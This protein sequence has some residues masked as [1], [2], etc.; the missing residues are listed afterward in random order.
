MI[1]RAA[2]PDDVDAVAGLEDE[3]LGAEAWSHGLVAEGIRGTLA[4][5]HYLVADIG[6]RTVGHA[7]TSL[8]GDVAELQRIGVTASARRTGVARA[9]LDH[10]ATL[11]RASGADRLLLEVREDN[12][13][14]L[15][16]YA[17][18]GFAEIDRRRRYYRD[19][20]A[21][22]VMSRALSEGAG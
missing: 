16:F 11:A 13:G 18:E 20:T 21:A 3:T 7:V 1:V 19:G 15:A 22:I 10:V 6:G 4:T 9:L 12:A 2:T 5:V 8:A 17:A 14:A